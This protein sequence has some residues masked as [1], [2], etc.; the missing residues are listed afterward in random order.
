M[1][2]YNLPIKL[3]EWFV[4]RLARQKEEESDAHEEPL[5]GASHREVRLPNWATDLRPLQCLTLQSNLYSKTN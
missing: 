4:K 2:A 1:E 3:R 5:P